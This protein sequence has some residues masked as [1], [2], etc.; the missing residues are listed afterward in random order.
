MADAAQLALDRPVTVG[1]ARTRTRVRARRES[2]EARTVQSLADEYRR[3][4]RLDVKEE[5]LRRCS[6]WTARLGRGIARRSGIDPEV[7][8]QVAGLAICKALQ[9]YDPSRGAFEPFARATA[10]GEIRHLLRASVWPVHVPRALQEHY[11]LVAA[12]RE[13]LRHRLGREPTVESVAAAA[14]LD[15]RAASTAMG[16]RRRSA[17]LEGDLAA[18]IGAVDQDLEAV[19]EHTDLRRAVLRLSTAQQEL[20]WLR[21]VE[22][23]T[24]REIAVLIGTTQVTVSRMLTRTMLTLRRQLGFP[25][26]D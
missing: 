23:F 10:A 5:I 20:I 2:F 3:T 12:V 17:P 1:L 7:V 22:G 15:E 14:D 18:R 6:A 26:P 16:L 11:R 21:F 4:G 25:A 8:D 9:R 24:Q 19:A 13:E